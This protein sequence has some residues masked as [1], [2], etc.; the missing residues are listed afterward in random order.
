MIHFPVRSTILR[1]FALSAILA[2]AGANAADPNL[3]PNGDFSQTS[4]SVGWTNVGAGSGGFDAQHDA[5]GSSASGSLSIL[6]STMRS[7]C[8]RV[9]AGATYALGG[10]TSGDYFL[11]AYPDGKM[12]C[13]AYADAHCGAAVQ[14][15]DALDM[16]GNAPGFVAYSASGQLPANAGSVQCDLSSKTVVWEAPVS[17]GERFD[18]L[19]FV[20]AAPA[21]L[22]LNLDGYLSGNWY[23]P[24]QSGHGFQLEFTNQNQTLLA[25]WFTYAPSGG[26]QKWI[27]AQGPYALD[28]DT[29]T[30]AAVLLDAPAF[31]PQFDPATVTHTPWGT[32]TFAFS[33]CN[34]GT[35]TW[36]S[37]LPGYGSGS[38]PITRLTRIAGTACPQ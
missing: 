13:T 32:L 3:L 1:G 6:E 10:K 12:I 36:N 8:F 23:D 4:G 11:G 16:L 38:L 22:A 21:P 17:V 14:T 25:I 29:V 31:P 24:A 27:Y 20:S 33:D 37:T 19:F 2:A 15:L 28:K 34:H 30:V 9:S 18:D 35:V 7:T 5:D 26:A